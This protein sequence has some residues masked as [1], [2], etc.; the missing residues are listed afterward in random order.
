[1]DD[2]DIEEGFAPLPARQVR[3]FDFVIALWALI[4][5][6]V[7]VLNM[8]TEHV[9]RLLVMHRNHLD[10]QRDFADAVRDDIEKI[11]STDEE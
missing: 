10:E 7:E 4:G 11:P 8:F 5:S 6:F 1:M 9:T 3:P 2:E